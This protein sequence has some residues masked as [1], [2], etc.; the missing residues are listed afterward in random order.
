[1]NRTSALLPDA[2]EQ[3]HRVLLLLGVPVPGHL[4]VRVHAA[5]FDG[6]LSA[7]ALARVLAAEERAAATGAAYRICPALDDRLAPLPGWVAL[8][9]W[10]VADRLVTPAVGRAAALAAVVRVAEYAA[11]RP[12]AGGAVEALLRALAADVPGG[13]EA[14][15]PLDPRALADAARRALAD[16][17]LAARV[18]AEGPARTAAAG[19]AAG[20]DDRRRAFGVVPLPAPRDGS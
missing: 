20:L 10:P 6:D 9:A 17:A 18:A 13:A 19:R 16:P 3:A 14:H 15:D 12:A 11:V 7:A 1:M 5:L 2:G 8:A 4:A